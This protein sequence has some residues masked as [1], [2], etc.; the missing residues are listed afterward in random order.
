MAAVSAAAMVVSA[1]RLLLA[2]CIAPQ[3]AEEALDWADGIAKLM[4]HDARDL[5]QVREI[6]RGP[7]GDDFRDRD[8]A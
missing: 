1:V 3:D 5:M 4:G 7:G 2:M 8:R 6:V